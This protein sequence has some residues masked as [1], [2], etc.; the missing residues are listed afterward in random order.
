[1][2]KQQLV[3][4]ISKRADYTTKSVKEMLA[5]LEEAVIAA[6]RKEGRVELPG[7]VILKV[8][9][10]RA[11]KAGNRVIFGV[12]KRV[13]AKPAQLKVKARAKKT[14]KEAVVKGKK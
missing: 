6:L 14:L 8:V 4:E 1:M 7:L 5:A 13:G 3:K 2:T 11:T 9:K 12:T 10:T